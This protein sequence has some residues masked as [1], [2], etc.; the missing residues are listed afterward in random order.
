MKTMKTISIFLFLIL[1]SSFSFAGV[2]PIGMSLLPS[3]E[4]PP[5]DYT[6]G[7]VR[8]NLLVGSHRSVY[9]LDIGTIGSITT[10]NFAGIQATGGFNSNSG[11][12]TIIL[13]QAAG[14]ANINTN[15]TRI[16]GVQ[17]APYNHNTAE[18]SIIGFALGIANNSPFMTVGGI[19]AGVYN[20]AKVVYGF[21]LGL[22]NDTDELH[23]FQ[24]GLI[25]FH[26]RGMINV[27]PILNFGF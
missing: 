3:F 19:Q 12:T 2:S 10:Q 14:G 26:R 21:Q 5:S 18:S 1:T 15:K 9:G 24:I 27:S 7:G 25:N 17:I 6:V 4:F 22:V 16:Y 20:R 13:L 8:A 11:Q 23:G